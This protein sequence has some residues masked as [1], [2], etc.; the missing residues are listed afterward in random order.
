MA[1][2]LHQSIITETSKQLK[3]CDELIKRAHSCK[4][5]HCNPELK[6]TT[7]GTMAGAA[8]DNCQDTTNYRKVPKFSDAR[9][10]RCNLPKIQTKRPNLSV[11]HQKDAHGIANCEDPDQ[12]APLGSG[13]ALFAKTNLSEN[14]GSLRYLKF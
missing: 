5:T 12:T 3:H 6:K 2:L 4:Y 7:S 13:S 11:L 10:L 9:K 14:L 8:K 1:S